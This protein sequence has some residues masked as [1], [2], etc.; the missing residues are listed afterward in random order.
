LIVA[1]QNEKYTKSLF[2]VQ[3]GQNITHLIISRDNNA[4]VFSW[5]KGLLAHDWESFEKV[6]RSIGHSVHP[7]IAGI[8][9]TWSASS[10]YT[11][12]K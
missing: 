1:N 2:E 7:S 11:K 5:K 6:K 12:I 10:A 4:K 9:N 3:K 8:S